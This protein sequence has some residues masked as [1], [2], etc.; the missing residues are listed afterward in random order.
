[1]QGSRLTRRRA[2]CGEHRPGAGLPAQALSTWQPLEQ[3]VEGVA[4]EAR[5]AGG[6]RGGRAFSTSLMSSAAMA[7]GC[8]ESRESREALAVAEGKA[9]MS[10]RRKLCSAG[11][12]EW[13]VW[14]LQRRA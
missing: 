4:V 1:V 10:A 6:L 7:V 5:A 3:S 11:E 12:V 9:C 14:L 2:V 13:S 8:L